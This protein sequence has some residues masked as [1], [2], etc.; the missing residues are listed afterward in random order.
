MLRLGRRSARI[1]AREGGREGEREG[2][3]GKGTRFENKR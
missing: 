3:R 1:R 2:R